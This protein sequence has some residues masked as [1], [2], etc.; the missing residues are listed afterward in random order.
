[1]K[2]CTT[3]GGLVCV[4]PLGQPCAGEIYCR[5]CHPSTAA[6]VAKDRARTAGLV[7]LLSLVSLPAVR[8]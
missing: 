3:C 4:I 6:L 8:K 1:M 7:P 2:R 5:V